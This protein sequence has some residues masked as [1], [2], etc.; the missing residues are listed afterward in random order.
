MKQL[1][2]LK[3]KRS[4]TSLQIEQLKQELV[5]KSREEGSLPE[6][7]LKVGILKNV[8]PAS[9]NAEF[10]IKD[11]VVERELSGG[12][13]AKVYLCRSK[14]GEHVVIKVY[15]VNS[16]SDAE[17]GIKECR[18]VQSLNHRNVVKILDFFSLDH[19]R[20]GS[21]FCIVMPYYTDGD[22]NEMIEKA[23][24]EKRFIPSDIIL[25]LG[26]Q[27]AHGLQVIHDKRMIH[28]DIKPHNIYLSPEGK[29]LVIGDFGLAKSVG[30][31]TS[32]VSVV[33]TED[34]IAP[35][36]KK[37]KYGSP[38]DI[39]SLGCVLYELMSLKHRNMAYEQLDAVAE[40]SLQEFEE[41]LQNDMKQSG[42]YS[43]A[44]IGLVMKMLSR[45]PNNRPT[46]SSIIELR[47]LFHNVAQEEKEI[48]DS[49]LCVV[50]LENARNHACAP[51]GHKVLCEKCAPMIEQQGKCPI[52]RAEVM[53]CAKIFE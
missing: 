15:Q 5:Q 28:R 22:L 23:K 6:Y 53:C 46:A 7:E 48:D 21:C 32:K 43:D 35:E 33:G 1:A 10:M 16:L 17:P 19:S 36:M 3:K 37:Q 51:C 41:E 4:Q 2:Q 47:D 12:A 45:N 27:L 38:A 25:R 44:L 30:S 31:M 34:Y 13:Q 52:C 20:L 50:C 29:S 49:Q 8:K 26:Y 14:N 11:Y 40:E 24:R 9:P 39:W 18:C 42:L